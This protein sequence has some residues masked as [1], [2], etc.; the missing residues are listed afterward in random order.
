MFIESVIILSRGF[1][2]CDLVLH[3][4]QTICRFQIG[5]PLEKGMLEAT[6]PL[7]EL[8]VI[9]NEEIGSLKEKI[10][11]VRLALWPLRA[12]LTGVTTVPLI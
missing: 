6:P 2:N 9:M 3:N 4:T 11:S 12:S 5:L 10:R 8:K 7:Q 1:T